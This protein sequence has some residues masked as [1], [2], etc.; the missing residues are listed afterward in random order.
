MDIAEK[1]LDQIAHHRAEILR[2]ES[3][4]QV[5]V[6]MGGGGKAAKA[7]KPSPMITIRKVAEPQHHQIEQP[8]KTPANRKT[9]TARLRD[10]EAKKR[11][12]EGVLELLGQRDAMSTK[13]LIAQFG[14]KNPDQ[15]DKQVIYALMY[16]LHQAGLITREKRGTERFFSLAHQQQPQLA[17]AV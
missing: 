1:I 13:E 5:F 4:L 14:P 11:L 17:A 16:E 9:G 2:L 15:A 3:A 12:R 7:A 6:E 10:I 8:K